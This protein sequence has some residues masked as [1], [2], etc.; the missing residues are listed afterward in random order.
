MRVV[1]LELAAALFQGEA[2]H[3]ASTSPSRTEQLLDA[4][5]A[6]RVVCDTTS[7]ESASLHESVMRMHQHLTPSALKL[8]EETPVA[9]LSTDVC[10]AVATRV[11][12]VEM[13]IVSSGLLDL[14]TA[15]LEMV[16]AIDGLP[17]SLKNACVHPDFSGIETAGLVGVWMA[18]LLHRFQEDGEEL[19]SF[20]HLVQ[21]E[22]ARTVES[23]VAGA[24]AWLVFHELGHIRL[25]HGSMS[26]KPNEDALIRPVVPEGVSDEKLKEQDADDFA[27]LRFLPERQSEVLAWANIAMNHLVSFEP[28]T[29]DRPGAHPLATNRVASIL[30]RVVDEH[31]EAD[32][33]GL[34]EHLIR[35][36]RAFEQL[37]DANAAAREPGKRPPFAEWSRGEVVKNLEVLAP[38]FERHGLDLRRVFAPRLAE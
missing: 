25:K 29:T 8:L 13:V 33:T 21:E 9:V 10:L 14:I 34:K 24:R 4:I 31:P 37:E 15:S 30:A 36:G 7:A 5:A 35:H 19:P 27:R 17:E 1:G 26:A 32:A 6:E 18:S 23:S 12:T 38:L 16:L 28:L 20:G 22:R 11:R 3:A 2:S